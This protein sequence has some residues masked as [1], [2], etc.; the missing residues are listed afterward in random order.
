MSYYLKSGSTYRV[1]SKKAMDLHEILPAANYVIKFSP[2]IGYFLDQIESF[3]KPSKM[4]GDVTKNTERL[5]NTFLCRDG[6]TGV[7]LSG[8]KGSG[9]SLLAKN[10]AIEAAV[11]NIPTLII[12]TAFHGDSFNAFIQAIEQPAII[13]L[14]EYEKVYDAETQP[15]ML[16]LLDGVY[17]S[18]KLFILTVN[19]KWRVDSH[20]RNRPGRIF[21]IIDYSGLSEDFIREY[22]EDNLKDKSHINK[23]V[24]VS[25]TF[26]KFNFDMLKAVIEEMNRYGE[27]VVDVIKFLNVRA[28][29]AA[30]VEYD[31]ELIQNGV[32][33]IKEFRRT[34]HYKGN[35][36]NA[37]FEIEYYEGK[38][39][40]GE[41]IYDEFVIRPDDLKT[42]DKSGRYIFFSAEKKITVVLTRSIKSTYNYLDYM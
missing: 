1:T 28:E 40:D 31:V 35:P 26:D 21:Y 13:L 29:F 25:N 11:Q 41:L 15:A 2:D 34:E 24:Q 17:P 6:S 32:P 5:L 20:M 42:I 38:D 27:S 30:A 33:L 7:L 4:Y 14:D 9:K 18:K 12:N 3:K 22:C 36:L 37:E 8:E 23:I 10:V 39:T 16:T 19:D